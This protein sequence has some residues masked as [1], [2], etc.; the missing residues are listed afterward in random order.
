MQAAARPPSAPRRQGAA[1]WRGCG[2]AGVRGAWRPR[3]LYEAVKD[4][5]EGSARLRLPGRGHFTEATA[6]ASNKHAR[7]TPAAGPPRCC[8]GALAGRHAAGSPA[9][10]FNAQRDSDQD[11]ARRPWSGRALSGPR[12]AQ[13]V[14]SKGRRARHT[15]AALYRLLVAH[16]TPRVGAQEKRHTSSGVSRAF[17]AFV[18]QSSGTPTPCRAC[19]ARGHNMADPPPSSRGPDRLEPLPS[20]IR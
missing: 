18:A 8:Q 16:L 4:V 9:S 17:L 6:V 5:S 1:G 7:Q 10:D 13:V 15:V 3:G 19:A 14:P 2:A 20:L 11:A 12:E